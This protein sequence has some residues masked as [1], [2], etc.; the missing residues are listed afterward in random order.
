MTSQ[1]TPCSSVGQS[2]LPI[3]SNYCSLSLFIALLAPPNSDR[4]E[5]VSARWSLFVSLP[6]RV[7]VIV[8]LRFPYYLEH[9][10]EV[11]RCKILIDRLD[12][13]M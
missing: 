11:V 13:G 7:I 10:P 3:L 5:P 2:P 12:K 9:T 8:I 1:A 6:S 4:L